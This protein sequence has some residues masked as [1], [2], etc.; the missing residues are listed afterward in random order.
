MRILRSLLFCVFALPL[1]TGAAQ[2]SCYTGNCYNTYYPREYVV[3]K[4]YIPVA[5]PVSYPTVAV[6]IYS[7][8]NA[9]YVPPGVAYPAVAYPNVP[10]YPGYAPVPAPAA[11][12]PAAPNTDAIAD[13]ITDKVIQNLIKRGILAPQGN[14]NPDPP[15]GVAPRGN[16]PPAVGAA[17]VPGNVVALLTT[18]CASCHNAGSADKN[19]G[20]IAL[21]DENKK[22]LN[23]SRETRWDVYDQCY[24]EKMPKGGPRLSDQEVE[25]IRKWARSKK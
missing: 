5:V 15:Q 11:V 16:P 3:K 13:A 10:G 17:P 19:G 7:Y 14:Q 6:P 4:E 12:A 1:L 23:L 2:A 9:G 24:E 8:V 22:L 20:G 18:K 21:F 25:M